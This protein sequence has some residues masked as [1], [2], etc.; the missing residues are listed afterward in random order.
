MRIPFVLA[1]ISLLALATALPAQTGNSALGIFEAQQD[2]GAN[3]MPGAAMYDAATGEYRIT[4]GGANIWAAT[5][6]FHFV[7]KRVTGDFDFN[8]D[9]Q[10]VGAGAVAHRKAVLMVRQDLTPDSAYADVALH[11]DGL[12]S[13]QFRPAA[14]A[15]TQE[16]RST[17]NA[18]IRIR[19]ERRGSSFTA[20]AGK[21]GEEL[22][23]T[24]PQEVNLPASVY[25]GLGVCS[26]DAGVLETAIFS[27]V[28]LNHEGNSTVSNAQPHPPAS[29]F[30]AKSPFAI[31]PPA[32]LAWCT[33]PTT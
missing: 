24:A 26:H 33:R 6:A 20:F 1:A 17:V 8:A 13:L 9:V 30:A 21:P 29:H 16:I 3:P 14:G 12:T 4:G 25:I 22:T 11:G 15:E 19:I 27:N 5:D 28:Q 18:P 23:A 32:P 31:L 10:F 7:W 2:V